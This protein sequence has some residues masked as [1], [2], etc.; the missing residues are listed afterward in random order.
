MTEEI[1][2]CMD[3]GR[4]YIHGGRG[5]CPN[6]Y[7]KRRRRGTLPPK[8]GGPDAICAAPDYGEPYCGEKVGRSGAKGLCPKHYQR[9]TKGKSPGITLSLRRAPLEVRFAAMVSPEPCQ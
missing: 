2:T 6:D 4:P 3:C 8:T 5:L 1:L 9:L 7:A